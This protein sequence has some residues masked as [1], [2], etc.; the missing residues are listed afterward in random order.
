MM[1]SGTQNPKTWEGEGETQKLLPDYNTKYN[2]QDGILAARPISS[3]F[4]SVQFL[5]HLIEMS[6]MFNDKTFMTPPKIC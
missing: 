5:T 2:L 1:Q 3:Q 6:Q 4:V